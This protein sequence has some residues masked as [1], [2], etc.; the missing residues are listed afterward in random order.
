MAIIDSNN[1][2]PSELRTDIMRQSM[3][4]KN[5]LSTKGS[6]YVGAGESITVGGKEIYK[7]KALAFESNW[8]FLQA[9][10][11]D[12]VFSRVLSPQNFNS[13]TAYTNF[14]KTWDNFSSKNDL[15]T[16]SAVYTNLKLT[17]RNFSSYEKYPSIYFIDQR[18]SSTDLGVWSSLSATQ[19]SSAK[20]IKLSATGKDLYLV[21]VSLS[22]SSLGTYYF[23]FYTNE[24]GIEINNISN[25]F[26]YC[27]P[28]LPTTISDVEVSDL[29]SRIIPQGGIPADSS[30]STI[31]KFQEVL[32]KSF[33]LISNNSAIRIKRVSGAGGDLLLRNT[34][35]TFSTEYI[36]M[37]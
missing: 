5:L 14:Q 33:W 36:E 30:W 27:C 34:D 19:D 32:H 28:K 3:E 16:K 9:Q 11:N 17:D 20:K 13:S 12:L 4:D 22:I 10:N 7:T 8:S 26:S 18:E 25:L 29:N 37:F 6:I 15:F 24:T 31:T 2:I 21:K 1:C 23:F 35:L